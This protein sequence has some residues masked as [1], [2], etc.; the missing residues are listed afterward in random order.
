[1]A[2]LKLSNES[3]ENEVL[4]SEIPV[5]V[6]FWAEWCG[7]CKMVLPIIEELAGELEGTVKV[8]KVN[9]DE[10]QELAIKYKIMTIPTLA[11]FENGEI[12]NQV[13]GAYPKDAILDLIKG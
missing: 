11:V 12:K 7:P 2:A 3:F 13:S 1:M 4:K 9:V 6:D 5:L 10:C 8:C